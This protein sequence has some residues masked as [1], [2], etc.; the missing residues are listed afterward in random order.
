MTTNPVIMRNDVLQY[1]MNHRDE[2]NGVLYLN[3][4][5]SVGRV[6]VYGCDTNGDF[7]G[8]DEDGTEVTVPYSDIGT[9]KFFEV[10]DDLYNKYCSS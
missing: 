5:F 4:P 9:H 8:V 7:L 3:K 2:L 6:E 1:G 10:F